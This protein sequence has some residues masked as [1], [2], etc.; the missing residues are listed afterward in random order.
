M[1]LIIFL[2]LE[3]ENSVK[4]KERDIYMIYL[5]NGIQ[6]MKKKMKILMIIWIMMDLKT[7]LEMRA[8]RI[9]IWMT[10]LVSIQYPTKV[11]APLCIILSE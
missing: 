11:V 2:M 5:K 3:L 6:S 10:S 1:F 4:K 8:C 9:L 7:L